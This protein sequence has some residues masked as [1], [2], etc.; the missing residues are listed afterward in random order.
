MESLSEYLDIHTNRDYAR[1]VISLINLFVDNPISENES[2]ISLFE[3][4]IKNGTLGIS[5][6][7]E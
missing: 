2:V 7:N 6:K 1:C 5:L 3:E 4:E